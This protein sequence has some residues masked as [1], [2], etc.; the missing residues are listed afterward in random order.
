[1]DYPVPFFERKNDRIQCLI[2]PHK[3]L[4]PEGK[5]GI[6]RV[7]TVLNHQLIAIN[8]AEVTS[9]AVDPIEKKPLYH[10]KPGKNILSLGSFG[11]NMTCSFCQN[12]EIS[13]HRPKSD[14]L[15][16][17]EISTAIQT[18]ENNV[19]I[20][21]TYNEPLMWY[22]YVYD[23]AKELKRLNPEISVVVVTN[24]YINEEPLLKLLPYVDAMN[25]D[26]KGYSNQ[27]YKKICGAKLDPVLETI[28][29]ASQQVHIEITTLLVTDEFDALKEVEEISKFLASVNKDIPL[30]LSRYFPRYK[31]KNEAT[32]VEVMEQAVQIA[33]KYLNY[34]YIGN[35]A[36]AD[37][38]TYCPNC[39]ELLVERHYYETKC[40]INEAT[41]PSCHSKIA[42]VL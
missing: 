14:T 10:F 24:G 5:T 17:N 41:C 2:C 12:Y 32:N 20:A 39:H 3:C 37:T 25:I 30:H 11:C 21:Y 1:M 22:E 38:N 6:C 42:I 19:G 16:I 28:K 35:V 27:Y 8:Y 31:M 34:V 4:I 15:S 13:Q 33:K 9:A 36:G 40:L 29:L 7:R 23:T 18:I 26:L